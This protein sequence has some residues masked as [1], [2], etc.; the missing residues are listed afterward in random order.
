MDEPE[1]FS[2]QNEL[3]WFVIGWING[4][5][6]T[7]SAPL[8]KGAAVET[9]ALIADGQAKGYELRLARRTVS[10]ELEKEEG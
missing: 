6:K 1:E 9:M 5:W 2:P 3:S 4:S 8:N 7:L 10:F